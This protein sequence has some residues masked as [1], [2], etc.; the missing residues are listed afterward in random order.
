M[1]TLL[2]EEVDIEYLLL[3]IEDEPEECSEDQLRDSWLF[4]EAWRVGMI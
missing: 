2:L 3:E 4:F 1:N